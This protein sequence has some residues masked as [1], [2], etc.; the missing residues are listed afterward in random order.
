MKKEIGTGGDEKVLLGKWNTAQT[1]QKERR[2]SRC[3]KRDRLMTSM[4]S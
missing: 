4:P 2:T 1:L 3:Y